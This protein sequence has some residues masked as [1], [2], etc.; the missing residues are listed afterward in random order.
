MKSIK[1]KIIFPIFMMFILFTSITIAQIRAVQNNLLEVK[2]MNE[3][4]FA[5]LSKAEELKLNVVQV[6]QWLTDISATRG[7]E[8]YNDG[9]ENAEEHAKGAKKNL[10]ELIKINPENSGQIQSIEKSF[11]PY[12]ETGKI[13]ANA[14]ITGGPGKGNATMLKFDKMAKEVNEQV[15]S[16]KN[17]SN[18]N[19]KNVIA[20]I[21]RDIYVTMGIMGVSI[22]IAIIILIMAWSYVSKK[23]VKPI[24]NVLTKLREMANSEGDLTQHIEVKSNDE[25]G[26]LAQNINLLQDSFR[27]IIST[28]TC[29][30]SQVGNIVNKTNN[31]I[32]DLTLQIGNVLKTTEEMAASMEESAASTEEMDASAIEIEKAI[33]DISSKAENG[34]EVIKEISKHA[35]ELKQNAV[36]AQQTAQTIGMAANK[37]LTDAIEQSKAVEEISLLTDAILQIAS[38]TNLL[39]LNA[40]IEAARAGEAGRGFAVVANEIKKLSEDSKNA[41][42]KIQQVTKRVM[43]SVGNLSES[44]SEI[45]DFIKQNVIKDYESLVN[46]GEQ[47]YKNAAYMEDFVSGLSKVLDEITVSMES[48]TKSIGEVAASNNETAQGTESIAESTTEVFDKSNEVLELINTTSES[49]NKLQGMVA[50]FKV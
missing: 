4:Y 30:S 31:N 47:Y 3:K 17:T 28:I 21:Q 14:Y 27:N 13:M 34:T 40:S 44:S 29:E 18:E 45:L 36:V 23:V 50:K 16:F 49:V 35:E 39:A 8:G 42:S 19:I 12:Y 41:V 9:F 43:D 46:T 10:Q 24:F 15:D 48:V 33:E 11:E 22:I 26:E 38:Q 20:D 1:I 2:Q 5:T 32:Q 25:I 37:K 7:A 6:Q